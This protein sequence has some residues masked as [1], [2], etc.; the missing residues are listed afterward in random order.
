MNPV[1]YLQ[2]ESIAPNAD[3][4]DKSAVLHEV[5]RLAKKNPIL[6]EVG[7][8]T[9]FEGLKKREEL[10]STGFGGG[11]AI[12]HCRLESISDFVMGIMTV[13]DGVDFD[14]M[15]GNPVRLVV[16]VIAPEAN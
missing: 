15:D 10:G 5:V 1:E 14:A 7:E 16:F 12:P 13:P 3:V 9:L 8:D 2:P 4:N 11:I 6:S